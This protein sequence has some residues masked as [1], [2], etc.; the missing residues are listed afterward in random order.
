MDERVLSMYI[1]LILEPCHFSHEFC[2]LWNAAAGSPAP[3][4]H[5]LSNGIKIRRTYQ[6]R[7]SVLT[8]R[9]VVDYF[10]FHCTQLIWGALKMN[11]MCLLTNFSMK[12]PLRRE[13]CST[14][15]ND[16]RSH[17]ECRATID[18]LLECTSWYWRSPVT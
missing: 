14:Q 11:N 17:S 1:F 4:K 7:I 13:K 8:A 3:Y 12:N 10:F 2:F 15:S 18:N 6:R 16:N 5:E 9:Q